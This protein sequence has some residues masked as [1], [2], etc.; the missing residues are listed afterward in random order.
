MMIT[1][2]ISV[3]A[4]ACMH[5]EY[6]MHASITIYDCCANHTDLKKLIAVI[7]TGFPK[8]R[9]DDREYVRERQ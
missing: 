3:L 5:S 7:N 8:E 4:S 2:T 1:C 9:I 6:R